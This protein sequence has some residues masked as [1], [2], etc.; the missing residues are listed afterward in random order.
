[1]TTT[2]TT[3]AQRRIRCERD[4][5]TAY[6]CDEMDDLGAIGGTT[7]CADADGDNC[8]PDD[9]RVYRRLGDLQRDRRR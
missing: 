3:R 8:R 5:S 1:M 4:L 6:D 7:F 9:A 2:A